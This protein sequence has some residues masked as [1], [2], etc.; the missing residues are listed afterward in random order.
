M[1]MSAL[2]IA[3]GDTCVCQSLR[4]VRIQWSSLADLSS[5]QHRRSSGFQSGDS[6]PFFGWDLQSHLRPLLQGYLILPHRLSSV[7]LPLHHWKML[8]IAFCDICD[9]RKIWHMLYL[10]GSL[11]RNGMLPTPSLRQLWGSR[12]G[13]GRHAMCSPPKSP[14]KTCVKAFLLLS[15]CFVRVKCC[16]PLAIMLYLPKL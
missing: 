1:L 2:E 11:L 14:N 16:P 15:V 12:V 4:K 3:V 10:L 9:R 7:H 6:S 5:L 8:K 13:M